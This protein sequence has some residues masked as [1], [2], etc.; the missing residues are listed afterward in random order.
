MD[1]TKLWYII[2]VVIV[3]L[4]VA[5]SLRRDEVPVIVEETV[6]PTASVVAS[7]SATPKVV[8]KPRAT[9]K[10]TPVLPTYNEVAGQYAGNRIQFDVYCQAFPV[11]NSFVDGTEVMLDNRSP[12]DRVVAIGGIQYGLPGYGWKVVKM[13][14]TELPMTWAI[15]CGTAKSVGKIVVELPVTP[16]PAS[17]SDPLVSASP[18]LSPTASASPSLSPTPTP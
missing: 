2:G 9:P 15:D 18:S 4:V 14:S 3:L 16:T 10:P 8:V 13:T 12:D 11:D 5:I 1:R 7:V 17:S 6:S